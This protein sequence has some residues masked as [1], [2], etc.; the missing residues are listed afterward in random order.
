MW[1]NRIVYIL[2][3]I[4]A[5]AGFIR[6]DSA[7]LLFLAMALLVLAVVLYAGTSVSAGNL[8]FTCEVKKNTVSSGDDSPVT[9]KI[10][11]TTRFPLGFLRLQ[12]KEN[13]K[14][15]GTSWEGAVRLPYSGD[16]E[17]SFYLPCSCENCG[18]VGVRLSDG[19]C[20]DVLGLFSFRVP[21]L[22]SCNFDIFPVKTDV[23]SEETPKDNKSG[24]EEN[25]STGEKGRNN[26]EVQGIREYAP[27]DAPGSIHWKLTE[28]MDRL[29]VREYPGGASFKTLVLLDLVRGEEEEALT[30]EV[31]GQV[32]SM[33]ISV[34]NQM[35]KYQTKHSIMAN[36]EN[37]FIQENIE[38]AYDLAQFTRKI[39]GLQMQNR[40]DTLEAFFAGEN[41]NDFT[42]IMYITG[43]A[44]QMHIPEKAGNMQIVVLDA[45]DN[46][47]KAGE[48]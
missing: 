41:A 45:T 21:G 18:N 11:G 37:T 31:C 19:V 44:G 12:V 3:I 7:I 27:G 25:I 2:G 48:Q 29:M 26:A 6:S 8:K 4:A 24:G 9:V 15:F 32:I 30:E 16:G 28:K 13:N 23:F 36:I 38:S 42:Q 1:K 17:R 35:I 39:L 20:T 22:S 46:M 40:G 10:E 5:T 34:S 47:Q 33:G 43:H 14:F